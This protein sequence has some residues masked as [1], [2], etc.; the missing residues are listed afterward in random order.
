[1][2][3]TVL[4]SSSGLIGFDVAGNEQEVQRLTTYSHQPI[5]GE[6]NSPIGIGVIDASFASAET[7]HAGDVLVALAA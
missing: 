3:S 4:A 2:S 6:S 1:M 7:V 5:T